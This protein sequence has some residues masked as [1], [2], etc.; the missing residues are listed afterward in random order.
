MG[1]WSDN[2]TYTFLAY[3]MSGKT[4]S[5]GKHALLRIGDAAVEGIV[6][7]NPRGQNVPA[8]QGSATAI[9]VVEAMQM[10]TAYPNPFTTEVTIPYIIGQT[11]THDVRLVFT[12]VAGL[13]IDTYTAQQSFGEYTYT[14]RPATALPAGVYFVTLY[15]DD[16]A[17]Q[18]AKLIRAV[19]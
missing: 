11:G 7:S 9:S 3:S 2:D 16:K 17:L 1:T 12:N 18:V 8:I 10:R 15:V 14:W 5:V 6:L 19:K 4:L 13:V